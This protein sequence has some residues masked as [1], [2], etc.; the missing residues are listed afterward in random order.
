MKNLIAGLCLAL[1]NCLVWAT[2]P[3]IG[4][5]PEIQ[6]A[7]ANAPDL[8]A[9]AQQLATPVSIYQYLRNNT[10]FSLYHGSVSG[11]I[12]TYGGMRGNDVDLASTLIAMLR[13][14]GTPAFAGV[15]SWA[16][17]ASVPRN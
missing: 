4:E 2:D 5:T 16:P 14:R 3:N 8:Y 6:Y 13:A 9:Q 7:V 1:M 15:V 11:S 10:E 17:S 12:N